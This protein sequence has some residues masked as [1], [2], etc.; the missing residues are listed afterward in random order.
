M[1]EL[2]SFFYA[3]FSLL[4]CGRAATDADGTVVLA[5]QDV[6]PAQGQR[7]PQ[8]PDD[9]H[10]VQRLPSQGGKLQGC[11]RPQEPPGPQ[12]GRLNLSSVSPLFVSRL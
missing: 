12:G 6:Q 5:C 8:Q 2:E 10:N 9:V 7:A 11:Q 1:I 3:R 4:H